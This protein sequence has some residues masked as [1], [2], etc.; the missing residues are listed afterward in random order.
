MNK[1]AQESLRYNIE[2]HCNCC[3]SVLLAYKKEVNID[4]DEALRLGS[5]FGGGMMAGEVCGALSAAMMLLGLK[6]DSRDA[7]IKGREFQSEF[8]R[9]FAYLRC[10]DLKMT[11]KL[12]CSQLVAKT[13]EMLS[14]YLA[15]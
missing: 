3:Q 6:H 4:A 7:K 14:D 12:P 11:A 8:I 10:K 1:Y 5:C 13:A 9:E 2:E 15:K